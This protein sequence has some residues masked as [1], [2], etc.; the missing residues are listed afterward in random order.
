M[1]L[2]RTEAAARRPGHGSTFSWAARQARHHSHHVAARTAQ[3][4]M[5]TRGGVPMGVP[6]ALCHAAPKRRSPNAR[7]I[8]GFGTTRPGPSCA[9]NRELT[10]RGPE[11]A[12]GKLDFA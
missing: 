9:W 10:K 8:V 12:C 6:A 4:W 11:Q 2:S 7:P 3:A 5:D 1:K